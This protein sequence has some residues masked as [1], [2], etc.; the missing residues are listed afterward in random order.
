MNS[1]INEINEMKYL[2]GYKRGMVISEQPQKKETE[3]NLG[4][5]YYQRCEG[6]EALI[7]PESYVVAD[8]MS[9]DGK[10]VIRFIKEPRKGK[11]V[12]NNGESDSIGTCLGADIPMIDRC[13]SVLE[14]NG[15][16]QANWEVDCSTGKEK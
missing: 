11:D 12:Y 7:D 9:E 4:D 1:V 14:Y 15:Q 16:K 13:W 10:P 3:D 5:I 6:G 2:L 8:T